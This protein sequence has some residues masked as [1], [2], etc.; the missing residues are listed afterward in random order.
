MRNIMTIAGRE[1]RSYFYSPIAYII[2][3]FFLLIISWMFSNILK[4]FIRSQMMGG[5]YGGAGGFTEAVVVPL[6]GNMNI[7]LLFL[8][9]AITMRLLAEEQRQQTIQLLY[10]SPVRVLEIALGKYFGGMSF[11]LIM[12]GST[13]IYPAVMF[14]MGNPPVAPMA[15]SYMGLILVV[16]CYMAVG[17]FFSSVTEN[18]IV[19]FVL[20][21]LV[22]LGFWLVYWGSQTAE[23]PI[24]ELLAYV[25]I[26]DHFNSFSKGVIDTSDLIYFG[27]FI[28]FWIFCTYLVLESKRWR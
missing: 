27:S 1:F 10:T 19:A 22:N 2:L 3:A 18:Q 4:F 21:V 25:S 28:G 11:A 15:G 12:V 7:V 6:W 16:G 26:I 20:G 23:G 13:L 9:P 8:V 5:M 14:L 24:G 17:L